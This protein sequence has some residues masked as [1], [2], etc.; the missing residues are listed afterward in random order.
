MIRVDRST[1]TVP[2]ALSGNKSR[3]ARERKRAVDFY[4]AWNAMT[5]AEREKKKHFDGYNAYSDPSVKAEL[6]RLFGGK[7]AYCESHFGATQPMDVEHFRPKKE[8]V[9]EASQTGI[10]PAYYWLAAE[11]TN[12]L[13]SCID[14]NRQ[15]GQE[16]VGE[17]GGLTQGK[18]G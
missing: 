3:G 11:W 4:V 1:A 15:R 7:C 10:K 17:S 2:T 5:D 13:P 18:S 6:N 16:L 14:C 8:V 9:N 12:L